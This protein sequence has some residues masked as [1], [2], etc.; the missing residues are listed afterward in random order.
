MHIIISR[1][2]QGGEAL[3][4]L[5]ALDMITVV[6]YDSDFHIGW[7]QFRSFLPDFVGSRLQHNGMSSVEVESSRE[8]PFP[9]RG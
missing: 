2:S 4:T 3:C 9:N 1:I 8:E 5:T 6:A 7:N